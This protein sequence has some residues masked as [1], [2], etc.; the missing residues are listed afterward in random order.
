[1]GPQDLSAANVAGSRAALDRALSQVDDVEPTT[2]AIFGGVID[3]AKLSFPF[4][5][6]QPLD[7]RDWDAIRSWTD[8]FGAAVEGVR[9]IEA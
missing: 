1:M 7:L 9:S 4:N 2:V 5:R 3:P 8:D 6:M